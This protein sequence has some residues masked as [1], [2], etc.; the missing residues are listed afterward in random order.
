MAADVAD[1]R[2]AERQDVDAVDQHL[3][4]DDAAAA[5]AIGHGGEADRRFAGARFADQAEHLALAEREGHAVD[6]DHVA[7]RLAR[8]VDRRLD[9]QVA[10]DEER[11]RHRR[12]LLSGWRC[13]SAPNRRRG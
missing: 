8:R 6:D 7:R 2:L 3:A 4:A 5:A 1:A 11:I 10:D 9:L 12:A 13:G